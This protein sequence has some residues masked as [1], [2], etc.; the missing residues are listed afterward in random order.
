MN[1]KITIKLHG[2]DFSVQ[3]QPYDD[4]LLDIEH[5]IFYYNG[6]SC[7]ST[8]GV[9]NRLAWFAFMVLE[10]DE[11]GELNAYTTDPIAAAWDL[12]SCIKKA[13]LEQGY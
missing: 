1:K 9:P 7:L 2:D 12:E 4:Y 8:H 13:L 10:D 3:L 5:D 11:T 6:P